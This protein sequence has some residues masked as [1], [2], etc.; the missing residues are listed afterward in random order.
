MKENNKKKR[1]APGSTES[2]YVDVKS[3]LNDFSEAYSDG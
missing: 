1:I 2:L 3:E